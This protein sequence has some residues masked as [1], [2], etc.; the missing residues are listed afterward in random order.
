MAHLSLRGN[1]KNY[2]DM[3]KLDDIFITL[4]LGLLVIILFFVLLICV[5]AFICG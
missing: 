4:I 5:H 2:I 3:D 1:K